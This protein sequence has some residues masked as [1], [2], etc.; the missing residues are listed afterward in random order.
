MT[1]V[2]FI[3]FFDG[4]CDEESFKPEKDSQHWGRRDAIVRCITMALYESIGINNKSCNN[5]YFIFNNNND[6]NTKPAAIVID[7]GPE[8]ATS[9]IPIE[10][11]II[12]KLKD[13]A[14][15]AS[16]HTKKMQLLSIQNDNKQSY[17]CS[18]TP[19][20]EAMLIRNKTSIVSNLMKRPISDESNNT[21]KRYKQSFDKRSLL[22]V[23]QQE[24]SIEFLRKHA[25]NGSEALILKKKN[26]SS[27]EKAFNEWNDSSS[28]QHST[29]INTSN[30][31]ND[32]DSD[33]N[34][35][36][37]LLVDTLRV[38]LY[39]IIKKLELGNEKKKISLT[40]ML[41]H[42]NAKHELGI[43]GSMAFDSQESND[44]ILYHTVAILGGVRDMTRL[45][46]E[47]VIEAAESLGLHCVGANLGKVAEFTSKIICA[48][49]AH[50]KMEKRMSHAARILPQ[51]RKE[52]AKGLLS[53]PSSSSSSSLK[54][55]TATK[56]GSSLLLHCI[57]NVN[58]AITEVSSSIE[59]R[60]KMHPIIQALVC[61]LWRSRLAKTISNT[62]DDDINNDD[63]DASIHTELTLVFKDDVKI[64]I[65]QRSFLNMMSS[66]HMS[67]P[68]EHQVI[69][70]FCS[71]LS[72][73]SQNGFSSGYSCLKSL[74]PNI[75][76]EDRKRTDLFVIDLVKSQEEGVPNFADGIYSH[77]CFCDTND[78]E[79]EESDKYR[80]KYVYL[81]LDS[82][83]RNDAETDVDYILN[84]WKYGLKK[85]NKKH[86]KN[87]KSRMYLK[88]SLFSNTISHN[89]SSGCIITIMQHWGY[90]GLLIPY[91][92]NS[93]SKK[94]KIVFD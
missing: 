23:L 26:M 85:A 48:M 13:S 1:T 11:N 73:T 41:L 82:D 15:L 64:T 8:L 22:K 36:N 54:D 88:A 80:V 42:E 40:V 69:T 57:L 84:E 89:Y 9:V 20:V 59:D 53:P 14:R 32:N 76:Q 21:T 4:P 70:T 37:N 29:D 47:C 51:L 90:H 33:N 7:G 39:R 81:L 74:L 2:S 62:S 75:K 44:D 5:C 63:S 17:T 56:T 18:Y 66:Q 43:F 83:I 60:D 58:L 67:A 87:K 77:N 72:S 91:I 50:A 10:K 3:L 61:C 55:E 19:W 25:L 27:I 71:I 92:S 46:V 28:H 30:N 34:D 79:Y 24:A 52:D 38:L 86:D 12:R 45:E 65:S 68:S 49:N 16:S 94:K 35:S 6:N 31:D 93:L 78:S